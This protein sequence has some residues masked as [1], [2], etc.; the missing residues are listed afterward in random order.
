MFAG[1][2]PSGL[3]FQSLPLEDAISFCVVWKHSQKDQNSINLFSGSHYFSQMEDILHVQASTPH[4]VVSY[5]SE[6]SHTQGNWEVVFK[7]PIA[8]AF[9]EKTAHSFWKGRS[10]VKELNFC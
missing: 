10:L 4:P 5:F 6:L 1:H 3:A 9:K 8:E 2:T 7:H